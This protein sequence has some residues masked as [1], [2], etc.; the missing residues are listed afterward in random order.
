M[1]ISVLPCLLGALVAQTVEGDEQ[2]L[3]MVLAA[4]CG[5]SRPS[6]PEYNI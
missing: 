3:V 5:D 4:R 2:Q 6:L 1:E